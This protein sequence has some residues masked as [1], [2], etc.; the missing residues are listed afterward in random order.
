M[1]IGMLAWSGVTSMLLTGMW[2]RRNHMKKILG[3]F[4]II[5][6][7]ATILLAVLYIFDV[8]DLGYS[9]FTMIVCVAVFGVRRFAK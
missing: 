2:G 4:G 7:I 9:I 3:I 1:P 6:S 8:V 5:L